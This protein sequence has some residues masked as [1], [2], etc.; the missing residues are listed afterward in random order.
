MRKGKDPD[1]YLWLMDPDPDPDPQHWQWHAGS[2]WCSF[3]RLSR[4]A[5]PVI[6]ILFCVVDPDPHPHGS[7]LVF[8]QLDPEPYRECGSGSWSRSEKV[9]KKYPVLDVNFC[10]GIKD[11]GS[12]SRNAKVVKKYW[13]L[14]L[15]RDQGFSCSLDLF[16]ENLGIS[17]ADSDPGS[18]AFLTP[19][20]G[21]GIRNRFFPDPWSRIPD[22]KP[23]F[24][25][26]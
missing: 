10:W 9:V 14:T 24:L 11:Q 13:M 15:L 19:G 12:G 6:I 2:I 21:S 26:A 18:G 25:R 22:P 23:I 1:P 16:H 3:T 17:V 5:V 4:N 20:P 8:G 7:T